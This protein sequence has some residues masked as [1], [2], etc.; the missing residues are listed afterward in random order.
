MSSNIIYGV[1]I[2]KDV[3]A[4]QVRD[5]IIECFFQAHGCVIEE[6]KKFSNIS[7]EEKLNELKRKTVLS[8]IQKKFNDI[9]A[10][11]NN[12]TKQNLIDVVEK[13][14]EYSSQFR[15]PNS[16]DKNVNDIMRL[17]HLIR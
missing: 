2:S 16:I 10:D 4:I 12:P 1:D 5:A 9:G 6:I 7:S 13:L 8:I 3:T 17:I 14:A 11:F 15:N